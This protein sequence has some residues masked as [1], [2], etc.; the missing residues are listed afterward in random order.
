M[1]FGARPEAMKPRLSA[2]VDAVSGADDAEAVD[3]AA[4]AD[5]ADA[6]ADHRQRVGQ[7]GVGA[8]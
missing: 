5:G 1:R 4:D 6:E 7:R 3:Q 8:A 2:S